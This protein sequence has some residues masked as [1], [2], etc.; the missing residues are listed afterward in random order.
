MTTSKDRCPSWCTVDHRD[1]IKRVH[2]GRSHKLG[3]GEAVARAALDPSWSAPQIF[4]DAAYWAENA[5]LFLDPGE[6]VRLAA[7]LEHVGAAEF[8]GLIRRA[9]AELAEDEGEAGR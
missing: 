7:V 4:V 1:E 5:W 6:A 3:R 9:C 8:A 2:F